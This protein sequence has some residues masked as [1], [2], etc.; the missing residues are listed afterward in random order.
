MAVVKR[1]TLLA[2]DFSGESG[3]ESVSFDP[4]GMVREAVKGLAKVNLD[5]LPAE[6]E[7]INGALADA[8]KTF[9]DSV[10]AIMEEPYSIVAKLRAAGAATPGG[11]ATSTNNVNVV[12]EWAKANGHNVAERGRLS[13]DIIDAYKAANS[14]KV[15]NLDDDGPSADDLAEIDAELN[16]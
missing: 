7:E 14:A 4:A 16:A 13:Q 2:S 9:V 11:A 6:A 10:D 8:V 5:A 3:A 1:I 15:T 12:R